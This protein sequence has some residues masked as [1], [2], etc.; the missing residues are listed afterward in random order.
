[1]KNYLYNESRSS[2]NLKDTSGL[3]LHP[4]VLKQYKQR[5]YKKILLRI[6]QTNGDDYK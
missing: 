2:K 4:L 1:M 5:L 6:Y 3:N